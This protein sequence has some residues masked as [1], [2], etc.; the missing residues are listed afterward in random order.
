MKKEVEQLYLKLML[1]LSRIKDQE[2]D[3]QISVFFSSKE[4]T[5]NIKLLNTSVTKLAY[6]VFSTEANLTVS[7]I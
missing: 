4:E 6:K 2:N 7:S 5:S 3:L 1:E